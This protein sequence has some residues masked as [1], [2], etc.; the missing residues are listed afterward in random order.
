MK[1]ELLVNPSPRPRNSRLRWPLA[2]AAGLMA[3]TVAPSARAADYHPVAV[4]PSAIVRLFEDDQGPKAQLVDGRIYVLD[5]L[6]DAVKQK[7]LNDVGKPPVR[8]PLPA[9]PFPWPLWPDTVD[10]RQYQGPIR[11]QGGRGTCVS[12]STTAAVE[13]RY[14]RVNPA[15]YAS[16]D[17]SEQWANHLQKMVSLSGDLQPSAADREDQIGA[18]GGSDNHYLMRVLEKYGEPLES[19][20]PYNPD[21][22][23]GPA[24]D[25]S[26]PKIN[27]QRTTDDFNLDPGVLP[28]SALETAR[29]RPTAVT[30]LS[31]DQVRDPS[32]LE[33]L[34]ALGYDVVFDIALASSAHQNSDYVWTPDD[35]AT[36]GGG[37][38][39]LIVGY[40]RPKQ[41]FI[42]RNSWGY[43]TSCHDN[44]YVRM[45]YD[46]FRKFAYSG[47]F[48]TAV[49]DPGADNPQSRL[50]VGRWNMN[51]DGWPGTLDIYRLPGL[52]SSSELKGQ[53]DDRIGTYFASWNG[54][55]YRV[56]GYLSGRQ[57]VFFI[58]F[59]SPDSPYGSLAGTRFTADLFSW[60]DQNM[61][62]LELQDGRT[63]SFMASKEPLPVH[64]A[65]SSP[66]TFR[67]AHLGHWKM[68]HDGWNGD[69]YLS[70]GGS[71]N[72]IVGQ[73][74]AQDGTVHSVQG[75][76]SGRNFQFRIWF[77]GWQSFSGYLY[78][79]DKGLMAGVTWWNGQEFG[80]Q[81]CRQPDL[82]RIPIHVPIH[83]VL[84]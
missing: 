70:A 33:T 27:L 39:M 25:P 78:S 5:T 43:D 67:D 3:M 81:A 82:P 35:G 26:D 64:V 42:V 13:G 76:V 2:L 77:G 40:N 73:Y 65:A 23:Y 71:A 22:S 4:V 16:L 46:Y 50:Y 28:L 63:Y 11:D 34:V 47:S 66:A 80:F 21:G 45:S 9:F 68:N 59:N 52:F 54:Q 62:G 37:H 30:E 49:A 56:N 29:Y 8:A 57:L 36:P 72:A 1:N 7:L 20:M 10:N 48:V 74:Y 12:F 58:N 17:L 61:A 18:W 15:A 75:T 69:L 6:P 44:G 55:A 38:S 83:T 31:Y 14:R 19:V 84:Q 79:W 32:N 24:T 51:H 53:D 60:D 41:Y